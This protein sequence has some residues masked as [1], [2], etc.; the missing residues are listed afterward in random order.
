MPRQYLYAANTPTQKNDP[1][2]LQDIEVEYHAK[3]RFEKAGFSYALRYKGL[4]AGQDYV[5]TNVTSTVIAYAI[6]E[7]D[8]FLHVR[9]IEHDYRPPNIPGETA[10]LRAAHSEELIKQLLAKG[11][12]KAKVY[13]IQI[14][15]TG[16]FGEGE[17]Q[18]AAGQKEAPKVAGTAYL[19]RRTRGL[20]AAQQQEVT[21]NPAKLE[22]LLAPPQEIV[23]VGKVTLRK[24]VYLVETRYTRDYATKE[25][26]LKV[27]FLN[28]AGDEIWPALKIDE[29]RKFE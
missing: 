4:K 21:K 10:D 15:Q 6:G 16:I 19:A 12:A 3:P 20:T 14:H 22:E 28:P 27:R 24:E 17:L 26:T 8:A 18:L 1:L 29:K 9:D 2:G 7:T 11:G 23:N 25:E 5:Q 13:F